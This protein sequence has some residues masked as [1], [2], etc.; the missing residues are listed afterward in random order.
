VAIEFKYC[1]ADPAEDDS[2][3]AAM[4]FAAKDLYADLDD[5]EKQLRRCKYGESLMAISNDVICLALAIRGRTQ[6]AA[7][8]VEPGETGGPPIS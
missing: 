8:F 2:V 3:P 7:R 6:V 1:H 5:A 4:D